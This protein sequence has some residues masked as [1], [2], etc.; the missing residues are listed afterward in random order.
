M[1]TK[2]FSFLKLAAPTNRERLDL[3]FGS[4]D[5]KRWEKFQRALK[6]RGFVKAIEKDER[7]DEK[8][9]Q[10]SRMVHL[11]K[12]GKG[13]VFPVKSDSSGKTYQVKYHSSI[14]RFTCSC[15]DWTIKHSVSG[16]DCKHIS[17]LKSQSEMVKRAS[18]AMQSI[19]RSARMMGLQHRIVSNDEQAWHA[20]EV[21]K[22]HRRIAADRRV[23]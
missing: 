6:S 3:H 7:A 8:L 4:G 19:A 22:I 23:S 15:P 11:H 16:G 9:K 12:T 13:P 2:L 20:G 14:G 18:M 5:G 10:Y 21:N 1:N 17:K